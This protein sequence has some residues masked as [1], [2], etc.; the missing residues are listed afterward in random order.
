MKLDLLIAEIGSTTTLVSGFNLKDCAEPVLIG[1]GL[2]PTSVLAGD[3][4]IGLTAAIDDLKTRLKLAKLEWEE[5]MATSS[6]AGGLKMS[7][8]GLVKDMTVKAAREAALGAG[9]VVKMVTA[10]RLRDAQLK[11][12]LALQP[13]IILLAGGVDNGEE[14]VIIGNAEKLSRLQWDVPIIYAGNSAL[15]SEITHIFKESGQ[16]ILV[17]ANV[18][19]QIDQLN[20]RPTRKLIHEVF[21]RH[22]IHAPGM[23]K[24]E[25]MLSDQM[26]P[27]P[28]AVMEAS[29][30]LKDELGNLVVIDVG[31]ATTDVHSITEDSPG[32][33]P[34]LL[35]PEPAAKRTVEGDLGV[36]VNARHVWQ[37]LKEELALDEI[38]KISPLPRDQQEERYVEILA[39]KAAITAVKRHAGELRDYY[40]PTGRQTIAEGKDLTG[41]KW[42][43]GTG[44]ALTRLQRGQEIL[45]G[46]KG[47]MSRLLLPPL[48]AKVL[49]DRNYIMASAG[50]M[51]KKYPEAALS[52]LKKSLAIEQGQA[53]PVI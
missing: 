32:I 50:L 42:I 23:E 51:S 37:L 13:N 5:F 19:P 53:L 36:Y 12:I 1:Q 43:I 10:G 29:Q 11:E 46:L 48:E 30:L 28:G 3:V 7:V 39:E 34:I 20:V 27:T 25:Q 15:Q 38:K 31:G 2:A 21:A 35:N 16:E 24:I 41:V 6:A 26:M 52:L 49:I 40:G 8:H 17:S 9:A 44:G 18:Y 47:P 22:I 45:Q 33:K 4:M 14:E